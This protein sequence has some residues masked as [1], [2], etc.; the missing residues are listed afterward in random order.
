VA[1][2]EH[3]EGI[4]KWHAIAA[5]LTVS[6]AS[7]Q[8]PCSDWQR[9]AFKS[10]ADCEET[11]KISNEWTTFCTNAEEKA[12]FWPENL[13]AADRS[14]YDFCRVEEAKYTTNAVLSSHKNNQEVQDTWKNLR[15]TVLSHWEDTKDIFCMFHPSA[16]YLVDGDHIGAHCP[17]DGQYGGVPDKKT[18]DQLFD[19]DE[20]L[21]VNTMTFADA[22][23]CQDMRDS[24]QQKACRQRLADSYKPITDAIK[25]HKK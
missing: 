17:A 6:M 25:S 16:V 21:S 11:I 20:A 18:M 2:Q 22:L 14:G 19:E 23:T 9:T 7:A 13:S 10:K 5:L 4:M 3:D 8:D 1:F 15:G 12:G 24:N